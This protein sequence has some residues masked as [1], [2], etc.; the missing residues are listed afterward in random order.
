MAK[1]KKEKKIVA[2]SPRLEGTGIAVPNEATEATSR[3]PDVYF[4]HKTGAMADWERL[5]DRRILFRGAQDA[6]LLVEV[7]SPEVIRFRYAVSAPFSQ[8]PSYALIEPDQEERVLFEIK[9]AGN[10]ITI[11]TGKLKCKIAKIDLQLQIY[12][13]ESGQLLL[14]E[15]VPFSAR[16]TI[17]NGL[18][19]LKVSLRARTGEK[20]LGL[21]DKTC[22]MDL[23]GHAL[24][25]WNTDSFGYQ[26]DTDPLYR[27][28][29]FYYSLYKGKAYGLF[30]HSSWKTHFDF[31]ATGAGVTAFWT[32]GGEMDYFF[33]YGPE[34]TAVNRRY[35]DLTGKPELAPLWALGFHQCRWSYYPESRVR[36]LAA[37]FRER[38]IPCDAVYLDIDYMDGY[39]CFTWNKDYFPDPKKLIADLKKDGFQTVVMIDPGIRVDPDYEVYKSGTEQDVFCR[40]PSGEV[41]TG[42]V[43]PSKCVFPDYTDP[44]VRAWWA[45]QYEEMYADQE[46]SGFWNDMNEPAVFKVNHLTFP[47]HVLH[48]YEGFGADHRKAHNIYGQ[49]MSRATYEGLKK[50]QP[51]KRPF[52]LTRATFSGGQRYAALWTGDNIASWEHLRLAN[53]QCQRLSISGFS[54]VGT[55]IG[56]FVDVPAGELLVRWLQLAVFHPVFRIHSMGN[57]VDGASEAEAEMVQEAERLNRLDQEPWAFGDPFT[58]Q[59]RTAI[60]F[61]YILLPYIYTYFQRASTLGDPMLKPLSFFDQTD[62]EALKRES[63][64]IF[65]DHLL[66]CPILKPGTKTITTYL[67]KGEW[68]DFHRATPFIGG[69]KVRLRTRPDRLPVLVRAGSVIPTYPV[70]QYTDELEIHHVGLRAYFGSLDESLWYVDAGEGYDYREGG[71]RLASFSTVATEKGFLIRQEVT[72]DFQPT[73][74]A[75]RIKLFGMPFDALSLKVDGAE[76]HF[77]QLPLKVLVVEIPLDFGEMEVLF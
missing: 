76:T 69:Q 27:S 24:Q 39:R 57:N 37:E 26:K 10:F 30:L 16:S 70:Q 38:S 15:A 72:G 66:V 50:H 7:Y 1:K 25:N 65:G 55:D 52:V 20:Y 19:Y 71:Y 68:Y 61:R 77:S 6:S 49:Q 34:L 8:E 58:D 12:D 31:D 53:I 74:T 48:H 33:I 73:A 46:V 23:R 18:E 75:Y 47:D 36:E 29:P 9:E 54:F 21:G 11:S 64:F 63:E 5:G 13:A 56:G 51:E 42:P 3:Y 17:M 14:E 28:I 45:D 62:Q 35:M 41:M 22:P 2:A 4:M 43:W 44:R 60:E 67:P 32:E 59:A 40:R